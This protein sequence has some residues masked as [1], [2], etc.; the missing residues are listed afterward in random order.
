MTDSAK[1]R[2]DMTIYFVPEREN[3]FWVPIGAAWLNRDGDGYS[4]RFD[5]M[6]ATAGD[7]VLRK[8]KPKAEQEAGA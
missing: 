4:L 3:A 1:K 5:L 7:I 2:P 6:P 8:P